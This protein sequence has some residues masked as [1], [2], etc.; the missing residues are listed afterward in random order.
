MPTQE[1]KQS[2][3]VSVIMLAADA[4]K[5]LVAAPG[6]NKRLVITGY[7]A[8]SMTAAAQAVQIQDGAGAFN[9]DQIPASWGVGLTHNYNF[10]KGLTLPTNQSVTAFPNAAG[11]SIFFI[12][13][14]FIEFVPNLSTGL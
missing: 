10:K 1:S 11:P 4:L 9:V 7:Y 5:I 12:I 2:F 3:C 6:V 8:T 13:E 14:G